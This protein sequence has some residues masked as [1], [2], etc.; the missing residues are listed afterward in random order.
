MEKEIAELL[1][2]YL[3]ERHK[4]SEEERKIILNS[5]KLLNGGGN[6]E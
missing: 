2:I 5:F 6:G 1:K 4:L 3:Q